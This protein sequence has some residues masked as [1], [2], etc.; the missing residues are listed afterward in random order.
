LPFVA[1][2]DRNRADVAALGGAVIFSPNAGHIGGAAARNKIEGKSGPTRHPVQQTKGEPLMTRVK[3]LL[4]C[5]TVLLTCLL[6]CASEG[7]AQDPSTEAKA[8]AGIWV[9]ARAIAP[10]G[11]VAD[12]APTRTGDPGVI[13]F[14]PKKGTFFLFGTTNDNVEGLFAIDPART[15]KWLDLKTDSGQVF[16]R[17]IYKL[18]GDELWIAPGPTDA[19]ASEQRPASFKGANVTIYRREKK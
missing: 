1:R 10:N 14:Y 12:P 16:S 13:T 15:P 5:L 11:K 17:H 19:N 9:P 4:V 2:A 6:N 18:Q 8:L 7:G 3:R